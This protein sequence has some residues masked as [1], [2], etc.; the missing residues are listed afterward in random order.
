MPATLDSLMQE[1]TRYAEHWMK[2]SGSLAPSMMA[3]TAQG[4]VLFLPQ[5]MKDAQGKD[6]FAYT[7][8]L[9]CAAHAASAVV[10]MVESWV[11]QAKPGEK[12]DI[13]TPPSQSPDREE[14]VVLIGQGLAGNVTRMLPIVRSDNGRFWN[15]G[16]PQDMPA[17]TLEG[18]FAGLLPPQPVGEQERKMGRLLLDAMGVRLAKLR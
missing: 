12:L 8:R 2:K 7:V 10:L 11:A 3:A 1:A 4:T 15:L 17:T 13:T 16:D 6:D 5:G 18:R 14:V 9:I